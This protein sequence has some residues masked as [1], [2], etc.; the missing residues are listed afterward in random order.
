MA[1]K[2]SS[3]APGAATDLRARTLGRDHGRKVAKTASFLCR[4]V[5]EVRAKDEGAWAAT[6]QAPRPLA[7]GP[8]SFAAGGTH[9]GPA[10]RV[11]MVIFIGAR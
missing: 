2:Y 3:P 11:L 4:D 10:Q 5:D 9:A 7:G 8:P 6:G 1:E